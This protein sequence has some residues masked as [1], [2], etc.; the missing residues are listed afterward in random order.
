MS[1]QGIRARIPYGERHSTHER[2]RHDGFDREN[3]TATRDTAFARARLKA[4]TGERDHHRHR[5][6][7]SRR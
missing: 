6:S 2:K 4:A 1:L 5:Q 3:M 7:G